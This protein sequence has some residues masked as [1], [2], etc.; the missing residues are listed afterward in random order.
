[1]NNEIDIIT[2]IIN[3]TFPMHLK[4]N[5]LDFITHLSDNRVNFKRLSGY[6]ENQLYWQVNCKNDCVCYILL[7][8]NGDEKQFAPFTVWTDD[9]S[10]N[11]YENYSIKDEFREAAWRNVDY[12]VHCGSCSG[13]TQKTIFGKKF[14][15]VCRTSMRFT[16]PDLKEFEALKEILTLRIEDIKRRK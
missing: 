5:S 8:G 1:M 9:S 7:N 10:S 2:N 11:R 13:G 4:H 6:W 16:N 3:E 14:D 12:C 15:N